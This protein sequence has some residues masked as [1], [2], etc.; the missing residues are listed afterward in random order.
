MNYRKLFVFLISF[1]AVFFGNIIYTLSCGP[2]P[3]PYDYY[4]SFF[5]PF[6]K[7]GGYEPFYY[8]SLTSFYG[9]PTPSE[10][11][12]NVNDWQKY[13]GSK[14]TAKAIRECIYS[15]KQEQLS[16][17]ATGSNILPDSVKQNSFAQFL[18]KEKNREAARYLLFA[19]TCEP[20][21]IN[22]DPWSV[23]ER[24]NA[25]LG[26]LYTEGEELYNKTKDKDIRERYAFQLVR[27]Q[28]Y[29][30]QYREA[31]TTFDKFFEER[32][33]QS[34]V[35]FKAMALKAG[36][37]LRLKDSVQSAYLFSRVFENAPSLRISC[38]T[39]LMWTNTTGD[40][41]YPL[42]KDN[43]EKAMVAAIY[44][45]ANA[46]PDVAA[47]RQ[48]YAFD[49]ASPALNI[50]LGREINK[51][52]DKYF[53]PYLGEDQGT[54][55]VSMQD[56]SAAEKNKLVSR[57]T[58]LQ[59]VADDLL[60]KGKLKD[61]DLWRISSAYISCIR[62]DYPAAKIR[63]DEVK[64]K[65]PA[66]KDQ[67]E[68][69]NL[70]VNINQQKVIDSAFESRLLTSFKW[71][72]TKTP[73]G[74]GRQYG[75]Y[76]GMPDEVYS[77]K[78]IYRN[79]LF[80]VLAPHYHQQ[81][82]VIKEALI[83]G[84]CDSLHMNDYF[85][86][87][88][89]AISQI[90]NGMKSAA[91]IRLNDFLRQPVK[92]PYELYLAGFFPKGLNMNNVIGVSYMRVHDFANAR[93]WFKKPPAGTPAVSYQVFREQLQDF[94]EDTAELHYNKT[95]TQQQFCERMVQL[96]DKMKTA[97]VSPKVYYDYASA[98]FSIS[99]YGKTWYFV[100]DYRPSTEWY[101]TK[102]DKDPFEKQYFGCYAA[103]SYYQKAAQASTDREFRARCAFMAARCSQKHTAENEDNN[104]YVSA[105]I[106]NRYF[107]LLSGNFAQ[108]KFYQQV[109]DQCSYLKDYVKSTRKK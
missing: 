68:I 15:Y 49:P 54:G 53:S 37:L 7:G 78:K 20:A 81:G 50:L 74:Q 85:V 102:C 76:L 3:D 41:V 83:R 80:A 52:E 51:L 82:D 69:V 88:E 30:K 4:I 26:N 32:D 45:F 84:R 46:E 99:Y 34:L 55:L 44:G 39:S 1:F 96:Q 28:H 94:G 59:T 33:K 24:N 27:L 109:Y 63:L 29:S 21:V 58:E 18:S 9:D 73:A 106:H 6:A 12:A 100:K 11:T 98:L 93:D 19:K 104:K 56:Y 79:L 23:P 103:E 92:S 60:A 62:K 40:Q 91:L 36:A 66:I 108:T 31:V 22:A 8:T 42:C 17:I 107:P 67:W 13:T 70:L 2:T 57:L 16:V 97:P 95:I 72:D 38:F 48:V 5:S 35:Y 87:G 90:T 77:F 64:T 14:V 61:M 43:H 101:S 86:S 47:I 25:L 89:T 65:D 75:E 71:L 105:L 10:E